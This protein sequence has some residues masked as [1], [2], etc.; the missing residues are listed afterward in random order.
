VRNLGG[1]EKT[2]TKLINNG[3]GFENPLNALKD[4]NDNINSSETALK[5]MIT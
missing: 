5:N 1:K 4:G 2:I 3:K